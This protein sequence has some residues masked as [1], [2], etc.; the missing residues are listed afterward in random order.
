VKHVVAGLIDHLPMAVSRFLVR[1]AALARPTFKTP[2]FERIFSKV[3]R[4]VIDDTGLVETNMGI[5]LRLR[6]RLPL[7]KIAYVFGRPQN[8]LSQ[9]GTYEL[10][11]QLCEDCSNF[12]DVG[13]HEGLFTL[14]IHALRERKIDLHFFEPDDCLYE[15]VTN[16]LMANR[17]Y[18]RGNRAA[19]A[20]QSGSAVFLKNLD[21]DLSGSLTDYF[22]SEHR[23]RPEVVRTIALEDYFGKHNL[24][25]AIVKIDV[26]GAGSEAW[27]GVGQAV[28]KIEY[29]VIEMLE[30]EVSSGL[31]LR[32]ISETGW[33]AYYIRDFDLVHSAGGEFKYVH[34]H[35]N[36]LFCKLAPGALAE[37][38]LGT[39]F[40]VVAARLA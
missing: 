25:R 23:T 40:Q 13:A 18:A 29:L 27:A 22:S 6:C 39:K 1:H 19:V 38:L 16:N 4:G 2:L 37:R 12:L 24:D 26:E 20:G 3:A 10:V 28:S 34:P 7:R 11:G 14:G 31:A 9:R 30:P 36:W 35:V 32:I 17:I 15:R 8:D 21:D 33:Q 5:S